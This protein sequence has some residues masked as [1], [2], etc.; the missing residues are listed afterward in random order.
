LTSTPPRQ[1]EI[2]MLEITTTAFQP[3]PLA[4]DGAEPLTSVPIQAATAAVTCG[5][6]GDACDGA[7]GCCDDETCTCSDG[8]C[9][10]GCCC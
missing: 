10:D 8:C 5:C 6:D 2:P 7:E 9:D 4:L 1:K 3:R